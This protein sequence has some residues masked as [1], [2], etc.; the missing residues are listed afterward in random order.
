MDTGKRKLASVLAGVIALLPDS[1][2]GIVGTDW[3]CTRV[4]KASA[5]AKA[6]W[7]EN[8]ALLGKRV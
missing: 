4:E 1:V 3:I 8:P 2:R 7:E 5:A 6:L